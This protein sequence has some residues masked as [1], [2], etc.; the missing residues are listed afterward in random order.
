MLSPLRKKLLVREEEADARD[1]KI[2][3]IESFHLKIES[4]IS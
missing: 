4:K 1:G 2:K 3:K